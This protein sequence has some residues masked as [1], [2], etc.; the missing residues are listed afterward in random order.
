MNPVLP[1]AV[2]AAI[3]LAQ[4]PAIGATLEIHTTASGS[5]HRLALTASAPFVH[6][7]QPPE[8]DISVFVDPG[9]TFQTLLGIG[10]AITDASA[11]VFARLSPRE[12]ERLLRAYYDPKDGIGY[13]LARTTIHSS[14]FSSVSYTYV[15]EGD[16]TLATF[17]VAH[18]REFRIP[19]IRRAIAQVVFARTSQR[20]I[21]RPAAP[22]CRGCT[23]PPKCLPGPSR[24]PRPSSCRASST[25]S[26][27][28]RWHLLWPSSSPAE[29]L[30]RTGERIPRRRRGIRSPA[31]QLPSRASTGLWSGGTTSR[32]GPGGVPSPKGEPPRA[33]RPCGVAQFSSAGPSGTT[34]VGFTSECT[35]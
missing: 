33:S 5:D 35:T 24:T 16:A 32:A 18:D 22:P 27:P 34:P 14:D 19:L 31:S 25:A 4:A 23:T 12:Q 29:R 1:A 10:G 3:G 28:R 7:Q 20:A 15:A 9:K 30:S 11:E 13:T 6:G 8:G 21:S 26:L 2:A 17:S